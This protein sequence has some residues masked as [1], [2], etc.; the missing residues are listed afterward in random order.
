M[1]NDNNVQQA[2]IVLLEMP[3]KIAMSSKDLFLYRDNLDDNSV[4]GF[5]TNLYVLITW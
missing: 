2:T 3:L 4:I 1:M 5:Y